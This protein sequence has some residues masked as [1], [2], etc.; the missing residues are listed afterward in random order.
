MIEKRVNGIREAMRRAGAR[1]A[2]LP[3]V[4]IENN[5]RCR[6]NAAGERV[7][8]GRI[9]WI[10]AFFE[11]VVEVAQ[12]FSSAYKYNPKSVNKHQQFITKFCII[13]LV[14]LTQV[15]SGPAEVVDS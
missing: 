2:E 6:R 4:L 5:D 11:T 13:P 8:D 9:A 12:S 7:L 15:D 14:L 10:P 3:Y 1:D